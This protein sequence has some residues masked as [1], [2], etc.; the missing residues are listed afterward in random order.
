MPWQLRAPYHSRGDGAHQAEAPQG[1]GW[2]HRHEHRRHLAR[3][4]MVP[5]L[6]MQGRGH[7][8]AGA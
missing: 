4:D 5:E 2:R 1:L 7:G 8:H 6:R 3:R